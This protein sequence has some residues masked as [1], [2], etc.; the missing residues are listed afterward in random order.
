MN[1]IDHSLE[2]DVPAHVAYDQWTQFEEFPLFMDG[3]ERV[4]QLDDTHLHW[5]A[6]IGGR[7]VSWDAVISEQVPDE[8]IAW[9]STQGKQN[10]GR[11]RFE[12]LGPD[13]CRVELTMGW[14]PEGLVESLAGIVGSE[15]R[16]IE[17]DLERFKDLVERRGVPTGGWRGEIH[18]GERTS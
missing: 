4:V 2:I 7:E 14:E 13:R 8:V 1:T 15:A 3:V 6:K 12:P 11:V 9:H 5:V 17:S 10:A 18:R 16:Q